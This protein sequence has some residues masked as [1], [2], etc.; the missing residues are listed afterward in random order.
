MVNREFKSDRRRYMECKELL[1]P[2]FF[3]VF[4]EL[5]PAQIINKL[6]PAIRQICVE[7]NAIK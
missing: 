6:A 1:P 4:T 2:M 7:K 3:F 5:I